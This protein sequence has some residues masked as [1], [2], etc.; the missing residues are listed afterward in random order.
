MQQVDE[1]K[2]IALTRGDL[3]GTVGENIQN[4]QTMQGCIAELSGVSRSHSTETYVEGRA[5]RREVLNFVILMDK[6]KKAV[7]HA[8]ERDYP[9]E[10]GKETRVNEG[11]QSFAKALTEGEDKNV[12]F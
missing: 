3:A 1:M 8:K 11:E 10:A 2:V 7:N 6:S 4:H 5:E 12:K 9:Q